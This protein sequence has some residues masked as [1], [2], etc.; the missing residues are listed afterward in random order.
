VSRVLGALEVGHGAALIVTPFARTL[1]SW[2]VTIRLIL[3][4]LVLLAD[5]VRLRH[6]LPVTR[7]G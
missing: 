7:A 4:G 2:M 6:E 3:G 5:A 1:A